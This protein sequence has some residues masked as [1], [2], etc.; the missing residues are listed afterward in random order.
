M[1]QDIENFNTIMK[2]YL[3]PDLKLFYCGKDDFDPLQVLKMFLEAQSATVLFI[4]R[5]TLFPIILSTGEKVKVGSI[6]MGTFDIKGKLILQEV[7][8]FYHKDYEFQD[9]EKM[10]SE[11]IV[12]EDEE[13][14]D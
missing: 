2:N 9:V 14:E 10:Y 11:K 4:H 1:Q 6:I 12:D 5:T 8:V 13:D 7:P 3:R